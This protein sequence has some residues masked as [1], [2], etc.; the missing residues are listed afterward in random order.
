MKGWRMF[1]VLSMSVLSVKPGE[2][3]VGADMMLRWVRIIE[4]YGNRDVRF[5]PVKSASGVG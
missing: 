4:G 5:V 3:G 2:C 1:A